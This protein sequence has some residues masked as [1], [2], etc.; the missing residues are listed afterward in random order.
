MKMDSQNERERH[1]RELQN[2]QWQF[3]EKM[4]NERRDFNQKLIDLAD[5]TET[6]QRVI[7]QSREINWMI[8][9]EEDFCHIVSDII[10]QGYATHYRRWHAKGGNMQKV[11]YCRGHGV[12]LIFTA[13]CH[14]LHYDIRKYLIPEQDWKQHRT[15][16]HTV[17]RGC[18]CSEG[19]APDDGYNSTRNVLSGVKV[20]K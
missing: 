8:T 5:E 3:T 4:R 10:H 7:T 20:N 18:M 19:K 15:G 6:M 12:I 16:H 14:L 9:L 13:Y 2:L 11:V 17:N 1:R